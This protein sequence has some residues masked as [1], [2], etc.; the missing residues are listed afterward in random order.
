MMKMSVSI[1][2]YRPNLIVKNSSSLLSAGWK[3]KF[4]M[5]CSKPEPY[6]YDYFRKVF[7]VLEK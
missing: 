1:M 4:K 2:P 5:I 3:P 6:V 7:F